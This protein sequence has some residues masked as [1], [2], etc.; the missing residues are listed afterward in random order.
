VHARAA[1][2]IGAGSASFLML[3]QLVERLPAMVG[4]KWI[5]TR[6]QPIAER[7]VT[8]ALARLAEF[9][10][11]PAEVQLGGADVVTYRDMMRRFAILQGRRPP[12]IVPVPVLSPRLSSYWIRFVTTVEPGL[13]R[14]LVDGLSEELL[15]R[16][17]PPAGVND[18]PLGF[19]DA[20]RA[21]LGAGAAVPS[22]RA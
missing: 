19:D 3:R 7:D 15:V 9:P 22:T 10:A 20:V 6:T 12:L 4:P 17:P 5:D 11:P 16:T 14:P 18:D 8:G 13:A 1:M 21:A 2:V